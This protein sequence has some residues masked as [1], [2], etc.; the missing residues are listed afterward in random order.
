MRSGL[1]LRLTAVA[2]AV[3]ALACAGCSSGDEPDAA[4]DST[5][6]RTGS[7]ASTGSGSTGSGSD[8]EGSAGEGSTGTTGPGNP[9]GSWGPT[10]I[11][12]TGCELAPATTAPGFPGGGHIVCPG[13]GEGEEQP[14][15]PETDVPSPDEGGGVITGTLTEEGTGVA[16]AGVV[17]VPELRIS[18][19]SGDDGRF[20]LAVESGTYHLSAVVNRDVSYA[21][22]APTVEVTEG[23]VADVAMTCRP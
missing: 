17:V 4:P 8:G 10:T 7:T 3:L 22:S 19:A 12:G 2:L 1:L 18:V 16:L 23:S 6:P 14:F 15:P 21:C 13:A 11:V 5:D 9:D 20:G